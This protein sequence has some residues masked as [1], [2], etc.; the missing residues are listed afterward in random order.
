MSPLWESF[1]K[2]TWNR[3]CQNCGKPLT[4]LKCECGHNQE[5]ENPNDYISI[6]FK[7]AF[8][9]NIVEELHIAIPEIVV[10]NDELFLCTEIKSMY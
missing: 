8:L 3:I 2:C 10:A 4:V 6:T 5:F 7:D 1:S 9:A